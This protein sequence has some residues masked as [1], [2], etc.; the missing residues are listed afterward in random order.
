MVQRWLPHTLW[1]SV[2]TAAAGYARPG[3]S[4]RRMQADSFQELEI[5]SPNQSNLEEQMA[6][7]ELT[8]GLKE[9]DSLKMLFDG[10]AEHTNDLKNLDDLEEHLG[11]LRGEVVDS[12]EE[13]VGVTMQE[14]TEQHL[15]GCHLVLA[16]TTQHLPLFTWII[17][18][19]ADG[20]GKG[21]LVVVATET[22]FS[23]GQ[24]A[25]DPLLQRL[26][27][28]SKLTCQALI[29]LLDEPNTDL[30]LSLLDAAGLWLRPQT[31]VVVVDGR[32][33]MAAP[34]HHSSRPGMAAPLHHSSRPGMA[35]PLHHS[36][37]PGMAA[38][39]H[40]SSRTGMA[41]LLHHASLRNTIHTL[42]ISI[43]RSDHHQGS[44]VNISLMRNLK[45]DGVPAAAAAGGGRG[46]VRSY[47]RCLYCDH[48][49]AGI[50]LLRPGN[51]FPETL[52]NM[53]GHTFKV[54]ALSYF[55]LVEYR[56]VT[57]DPNDL[58]Q[59]EDSV[60]VR[61]LDIMARRFNFTYEMR[62]P[63]DGLWG[64]PTSGG[65]W[66][67]IVGTL[68][69][70]MADF[71]MDLTPS[72][73]RMEVID[74][75]KTYVYD[76]LI[77]MSLQPSPLPRSLA[78]TRP[79]SGPVWVMTVVFTFATGVCLWVLQKA[80]AWVLGRRGPDLLSRVFYIWGVLLENEPTGPP[81][82]IN[83]KMLVGW[84]LVGCLVLATAYRSSLVAHLSVQSKNK[85][86]NTLAD[87]LNQ[88]GWSWGARLMKGTT[89]LYFNQSTDPVLI[90]IHQNYE[91]FS[92]R[93]EATKRV[94]AGR[95]AYIAFKTDILCDIAPLYVDKYGNTPLYFSTT[96]YNIFG[97]NAW[98]FRQVVLG[99][100]SKVA[101]PTPSGKVSKVAYPTPSGKVSKVAYPT[102]SGKVSKV[103]YPTPSGKVSKVAYPTPSGKVS[104]VAYPTP[105]G[106]VSTVAYPT[107]S[108]KVSKVAY[109]TPSGKLS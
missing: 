25:S 36:S 1:L 93:E 72:D 3:R 43:N 70:Q 31:M 84:W 104:T 52:N 58:V 10:K 94:L 101:Y 46:R 106:K 103:A 82:T 24:T 50:Q 29:L 26:W 22:L 21:S 27:S 40:H 8:S 68:Q 11:V 87:I 14:V 73:S 77:I 4:E 67:G 97:G 80:W 61:M 20:G 41:A 48:G 30:A 44:P 33:G 85:P 15:A 35:A 69:H 47:R 96:E 86:I 76:P 81:A 83:G 74:F 12:L 78:V 6:I 34:L 59:P 42:Y 56:K 54:V 71:S 13:Q 63:W 38:P 105:S 7:L 17:R 98:G 32:P 99:K 62:E 18:R 49:Q 37:R 89:F 108:G 109:P 95:F 79:F 65:N 55:P 75:S 53:M 19:L 39:L 90:K 5:L 2:V 66:S 9:M 64:T 57:N 107:P 28:G 16:S 23:Q 51:L 92:D 60:D 91:I 88:K 100:V 102:P 45:E